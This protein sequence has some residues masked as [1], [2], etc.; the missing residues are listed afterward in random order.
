MGLTERIQDKLG[1]GNYWDKYASQNPLIGWITRKFV[2]DW[3]YLIRQLREPGDKVLD[4]GCGEGLLTNAVSRRC[5][6]RITGLDC[7]K[8]V[9]HKA[10]VSYPRLKFIHGDIMNL[11]G[12]YDILMASEVLEHVGYINNDVAYVDIAVQNCKLAGRICLFS[13]PDEPLFRIANIIRGKYLLHLGNTP[14]HIN[15]WSTRRLKEMLDKHF[16]YVAIY[17]S[18]LWNLAVCSDRRLKV[19][20]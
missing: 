10:S 16:K 6:V 4:V 7:D 17:G 1:G 5:K 19:K 20:W 11:K 15:H 2:A 9:L 8:G 18:T 12:R 14:G 13:V 3:C